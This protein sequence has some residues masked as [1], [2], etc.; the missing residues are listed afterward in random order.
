MCSTKT[1][2]LLPCG[3]RAPI[4]H[5]HNFVWNH[6]LQSQFEMQVF[7]GGGNASFLVVSRNYNTEK[8]QG[9]IFGWIGVRGHKLNYRSPI[10]R[11]NRDIGGC[12]LT[13]ARTSIGIAGYRAYLMTF[14][15]LGCGK[16]SSRRIN[17]A[18][19]VI[20]ESATLKAG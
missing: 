1:K 5:Y 11:V 20:A 16:S 18:P 4:I 2:Q 9:S 17:M 3:I 13:G 19:M 8:A 10:C 12:C 6:L 7:N 15:R 14:G